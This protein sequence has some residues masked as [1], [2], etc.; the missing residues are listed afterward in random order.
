MEIIFQF[1]GELRPGNYKPLENSRRQAPG[2]GSVPHPKNKT[3]FRKAIRKWIPSN[4][5]FAQS[6]AVVYLNRDYQPPPWGH[7][8]KGVDGKCYIKYASR[9]IFCFTLTTMFRSDG[10]ECIV[11]KD[12]VLLLDVR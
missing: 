2:D 5:D 10:S 8:S 11:V 7:A 6:I 4:F 1:A 3:H 9:L 12:A